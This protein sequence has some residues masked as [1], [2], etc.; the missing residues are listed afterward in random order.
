[1]SAAATDA[2]PQTL[3][4]T[5]ENPF[6][7]DKMSEFEFIIKRGLTDNVSRQL[8]ITDEF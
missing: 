5:F 6:N 1:M 2:K 3:A 7:K 8:K 4:I